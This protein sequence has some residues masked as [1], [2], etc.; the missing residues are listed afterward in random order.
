MTDRGK[1]KDIV[2]MVEYPNG[3][4]KLVKLGEEAVSTLHSI[5]FASD[6][7]DR[8]ALDEMGVSDDWQDNASMIL[9][10][11][12]MKSTPYCR[13]KWHLKHGDW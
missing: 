5:T 11:T 6:V 10:D 4:T 7:T 12:S 1:I 8:S 9:T 3:E 13:W 2:F